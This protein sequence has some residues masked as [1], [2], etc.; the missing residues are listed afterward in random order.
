MK[1]NLLVLSI[2]S[3]LHSYGLLSRVCDSRPA[4]VT[5]ASPV[6]PGPDYVWIGGEWE[7]TGGN[8][9]WREGSWQH[10]REGHTW[11]SGIGKIIIKDTNGIRDP[12]T[13]GREIHKKE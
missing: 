7:W 10:A 2:L 4:D 1:N 3:G 8:Y 9:H 5:Y 12:G 6:S 11:K 13:I